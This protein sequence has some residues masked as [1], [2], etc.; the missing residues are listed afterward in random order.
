M[1]KI[2]ICLV[3][4]AIMLCT[5]GG[6][7]AYSTTLNITFTSPGI[8]WNNPYDATENRYPAYVLSFTDD[9]T[10]AHLMQSSA[11]GSATPL[12]YLFDKAHTP[13]FSATNV[14]TWVNYQMY[15]AGTA[16][17]FAG[18]T[19]GLTAGTQYWL[20]ATETTGGVP[21]NGSG[22]LSV[23]PAPIPGV[24]WLLASGLAGLAGLGRKHFG[25]TCL[26]NI[27]FR[28]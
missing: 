9:A 28:G 26:E 16:G 25:Y 1:K 8:T 7:R 21:I 6:A 11:P 24:P 2:L 17:G 3:I 23:S 13:N 12:L 18:F 22:T 27:V 10:M 4:S 5:A 14:S 20:V 15:A 19:Y